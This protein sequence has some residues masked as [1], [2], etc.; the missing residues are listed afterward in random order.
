VRPWIDP[1]KFLIVKAV[2]SEKPTAFFIFK[3]ESSNVF[4]T[5]YIKYP[6]FIHACQSMPMDNVPA[7]CGAASL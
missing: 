3:E 7:P 4:N 6:L 2:G 5:F 1:L